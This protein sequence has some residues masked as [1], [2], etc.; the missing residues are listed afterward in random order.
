[1]SSPLLYN[2]LSPE[3]KKR[4]SLAFELTSPLFKPLSYKEALSLLGKEER[5]LFAKVQVIEASAAPVYIAGSRE[6]LSLL[7]EAAA[8]S[9]LYIDKKKVIADF[10]SATPVKF[11]AM[12][13]DNESI[14]IE[15]VVVLG[16]EIP[17][18]DLDLAIPSS[19][20]FFFKEGF[21][22]TPGPDFDPAWIK[23][24]LK[25]GKSFRV[26]KSLFDKWLKEKEELPEC[27]P[28]FCLI[29]GA[30]PPIESTNQ[31]EP[32][33]RIRD[34]RG[35]FID[36]LL[37]TPSGLIN[38]Y[39][40]SAGAEHEKDLLDAGYVKRKE[41]SCY[42]CPSDRAQE[43][44]ELLLGVGWKAVD[45]ADNKI[46][47]LQDIRLQFDL[48]EDKVFVRAEIPG[49]D[50]SSAAIDPFNAAVQG[51]HLIPFKDGSYGL[52]PKG[53]LARCSSYAPDIEEEG[54]RHFIPKVRIG[55][56]M[57]SAEGTQDLPAN[58]KELLAKI[59]G[60]RVANKLTASSPFKGVLRPYQ[61]TGAS[62]LLS[63]YEEGFSGILAD[64]MGLGKT[65]QVIAALASLPKL[66]NTPHLAVM[67]K[68]LLFNWSHELT[69]FFPSC[70]VHV[71]TGPERAKDPEVFLRADIVLTSYPLLRLDLDLFK[72]VRFHTIILD[73]A[74]QIKN[75]SS[76][77]AVAA[78]EL[79]AL[80][81]VSLTGTPLENSIRDII[82][83]YSFLMPGLIKENMGVENP[84]A[85]NA[86][87]RKIRPF[88]LRRRKAEVAKDLPEI[89]R[90]TELVEMDDDEKESYQKLL[91][92]FRGETRAILKKEGFSKGRFQIFE[93]ILRLRQHA[94]HPKLYRSPL[95]EK[96]IPSAKMAF[97]IDEL[98]E[99]YL[100][101]AKSI[102]FSQF[103]SVLDLIEEELKQRSLPFLRLDGSTKNREE[104]VQSFKR[105][106]VPLVF[107]ISLK[108]GGVGLNLEQADY[109]FLY[110]PWWNEA[111]EE[112]AI[113]RAHRIGRKSPVVAKKY[114]LAGTIEEK[115]LELKE[116]KQSL[117]SALI[118]EMDAPQAL[119]AE[120]IEFLLEGEVL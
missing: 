65:V 71:H 45:K 90:Q 118:D 44:I 99:V 46:R 52:L 81:K 17:F 97:L 25:E 4:G 70:R 104:V 69:K 80:F 6:T 2:I 53:F 51:K 18:P 113:A 49:N 66:E 35:A 91:E 26:Q 34:S 120:D 32:I 19:P 79:E 15:P 11:Y 96:E 22:K 92:H 9:A 58:V 85:L 105:E 43:A 107:L 78:K 74:Q 75:S 94:C 41:D 23:R 47:L 62:W 102:V 28:E 95:Q 83:Q 111:V 42:Y 64:E 103:T 101:Q 56:L 119:T 36:F 5:S 40:I 84:A 29:E 89:I 110:E 14:E 20:P 39:D 77:V 88:L 87:R 8:R 93:A 3:S 108:A 57:G 12:A 82:S 109:V 61:E 7:K 76:K 100:S 117:A 30:L 16:K 54:G 10:F 38:A 86:L 72:K 55:S 33:L 21:L 37:E 59:G 115:I 1:M 116:R 73:E 106:G 50:P 67:P 63:L 13:V 24:L 98:E 48:V 31:A 60:E 112:Q 114:I 27:S 68:S